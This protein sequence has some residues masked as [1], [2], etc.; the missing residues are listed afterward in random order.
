[1]P[2]GGPFSTPIDTLLAKPRV[3]EDVGGH[4]ADQ[5]FVLDNQDHWLL[6]C[7]WFGHHGQ[8]IGAEAGFKS[9]V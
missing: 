2:M 3:L 6:V 9:G 1:M 8:R 5:L 4:E 7:V